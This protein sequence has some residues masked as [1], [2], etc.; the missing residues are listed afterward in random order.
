MD[1]ECNLRLHDCN[2]VRQNQANYGRTPLRRMLYRY[3]FLRL[4]AALAT[5]GLCRTCDLFDGIWFAA[6]FGT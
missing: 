4:P 3:R 5:A 2:A 6:S 1:N